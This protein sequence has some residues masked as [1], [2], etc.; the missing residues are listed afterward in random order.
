M[1]SDEKTQLRELAAVCRR[2][3]D[4][5]QKVAELEA[6]RDALI[7]TLKAKGVSGAL[8]AAQARLSAGR[9]TQIAGNGRTD[10]T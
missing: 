1:P 3:D 10:A 9:V 6:R 4:A 2:L 7:S 8:L 5:R